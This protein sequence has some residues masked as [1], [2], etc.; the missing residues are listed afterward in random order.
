MVKYSKIKCLLEDPHFFCL[1][2]RNDLVISDYRSHSIRVFSPE[3]NLLHTKER[4]KECS[5]IREEEL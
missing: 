5:L 1:G 2:L 4:N 3:G